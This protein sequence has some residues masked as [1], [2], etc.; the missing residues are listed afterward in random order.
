MHRYCDVKAEHGAYAGPTCHRCDAEKAPPITE[1]TRKF[2]ITDPGDSLREEMG[3][4]KW[5]LNLLRLNDER[6]T[7]IFKIARQRL[8]LHLHVMC[9]VSPKIYKDWQDGSKKKVRFGVEFTCKEAASWDDISGL[10]EGLDDLGYT[11]TRWQSEDHANYG[12][13]QFEWF[14]DDRAFAIQVQLYPKEIEE[15]DAE[16]GAPTVKC[17]KVLLGKKFHRSHD[18]TEDV[19]AFDCGQ[20]EEELRREALK[21]GRL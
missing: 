11:L 1:E 16:T 9:S 17:K 13:R 2:S 10:M 6:V 5:R 4:I 7:A 19:Y 18:Y 21:A 8:P 14:T 3:D 20:G 12:Y 15:I